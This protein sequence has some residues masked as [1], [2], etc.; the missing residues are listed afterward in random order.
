MKLFVYYGSFLGHFALIDK[1]TKI[2]KEFIPL[3]VSGT[4]MLILF[5]SGLLN[6]LKI[7]TILLYFVG[8]FYFIYLIYKNNIMSYLFDKNIVFYIG[9]SLLFFYILKNHQ[10]EH[11]DNYTHWALVVKNMLLTDRFP[12]FMDRIIDFQ[13]YP[14]GSSSYI[15]YVCKLVGNSPSCQMYGQLLL[16]LSSLCPFVEVVNRNKFLALSFLFVL[17]VFISTINIQ[18]TDLLVD[19]LLG[20]MGGFNHLFYRHLY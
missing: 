8:I 3:Y 7:I 17:I 16:I 9:V 14:L 2:K 20:C 4:I 10:F 19:T 6:I 13:T 1:Y 5:I 12:N 15:Y 18:I 11:I